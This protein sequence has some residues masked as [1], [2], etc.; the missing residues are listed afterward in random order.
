MA[1]GPDVKETA[2]QLYIGGNSLEKIADETGVGKNTI[3]RWYHREGWKS[4]KQ[5]I[6][7]NA[8]KDADKKTSGVF[9]TAILNLEELSR[10]LYDRIKE[11]GDGPKT[12]EGGVHAWL[13]VIKALKELKGESGAAFDRKV[14][15]IVAGLFEVLNQDPVI[16]PLMDKRR[17]QIVQAL[18][19]KLSG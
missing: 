14:T 11:F 7:E 8:R 16:G 6:L 1:Y 2:F 5:K 12:L 9:T 10:D 18:E 13:S 4:R 3:K 17:N 19:R 15:D